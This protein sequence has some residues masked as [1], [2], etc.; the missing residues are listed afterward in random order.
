M[1][2]SVLQQ[3]CALKGSG[4]IMSLEFRAIISKIRY[5]IGSTFC[6][7]VVAISL[8]GAPSI[9]KGDECYTFEQLLNLEHDLVNSNACDVATE[10]F[11]KIHGSIELDATEF[12]FLKIEYPVNAS[13]LNFRKLG[14][15]RLTT[16]EALDVGSTN[17]DTFFFYA[18]VENA[19][20]MN[21]RRYVI[22]WTYM[23][24]SR[25]LLMKNHL[26]EEKLSLY[27]LFFPKIYSNVGL[28]PANGFKDP[29]KALACFILLDIPWID[30]S[31][32]VESISFNKCYGDKK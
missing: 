21:E 14:L 22:Y 26:G 13:L 8:L 15:E 10:I 5:L 24:H 20:K 1:K 12:E 23:I 11:A 3:G 2:A 16:I 4:G 29:S 28:G 9:G 27:S 17:L 32:I 7:M 30:P 25:Y 18:M 19:H 31:Q 6:K